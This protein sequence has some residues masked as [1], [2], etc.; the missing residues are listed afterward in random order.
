MRSLFF[1]LFFTAAVFSGKAQVFYRYSE[2]GLFG[3]MSYYM[4]DLNPGKP[5]FMA[6]PALGVVY[7]YNTSSRFAWRFQGT[8]G[9]IRADD[10]LSGM[11]HQ[12]QRNL[13]FRSVLLEGAAL[14]EF[15]FFHY[16]IANPEYPATFFLFGGIAGYH[17]NPK[18]QFNG[19]WIPLQPLGTEGQA[20]YSVRA[21]RRYNLTQLSFPFGVGVKFQ[22]QNVIGIGFEWG[23]RR[24][25]TD[26]LDDVSTVYADPD[27]LVEAHGAYA[28]LL[29]DRSLSN[30]GRS[31]VGLQRGNPAT[32]D[33]YSFAGIC[34]TVRFSSPRAE[35]AAYH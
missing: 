12:I 13:S 24:T 15:N 30:P 20:S 6:Q 25:F 28:A 3:G 8:W 11:P 29:A 32:K 5:F 31:N 4:G 19:E 7:R 14:L 16:D 33:W 17:F 26:Y 9:E 27:L 22:V 34:L 35:C 1:L 2:A 23:M 18:A 21:A 10:A